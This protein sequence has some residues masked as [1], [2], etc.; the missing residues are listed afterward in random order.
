MNTL[1]VDE[2]V[3]FADAVHPEYQSKP[4]FGWFRV[5]AKVALPTTTGRKRLNIHAAFN[6]ETS[7]LTWVE[8]T[9]ISAET[10]LV[11]LKE[12]ERTCPTNTA[13]MSS[14][15]TQNIITPKNIETVARTT[16]LPHQVAFPA[17]IRATSQPDR[18]IMGDHARARYPQ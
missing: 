5:D 14:R 18:A 17:R 3:V 9:K 8:S 11:G 12:L 2:G 13:S 7:K 16:R 1:A 4:A 6:L 15:T 10:T